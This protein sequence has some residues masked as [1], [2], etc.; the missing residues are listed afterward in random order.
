MRPEST[1]QLELVSA[2]Y[3]DHPKIHPNYLDKDIDKKTIVKGIQIARKIAQF[4]PLKSHI[5]EEYQPGS[6]VKFDDYEAS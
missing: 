1:G 3:R 4:E 5:T 6:E 2:N